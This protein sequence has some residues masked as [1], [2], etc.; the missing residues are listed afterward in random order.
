MY[1]I[2]QFKAKT[3]FELIKSP[4]ITYRTYK[5]VLFSDYFSNELL[6]CPARFATGE[7]Q[8]FR[9]YDIY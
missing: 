8:L 1:D 5:L 4:Q 2:C 7:V 6:K 3:I 9:D